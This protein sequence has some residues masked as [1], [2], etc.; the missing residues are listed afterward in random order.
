MATCGRGA[1]HVVC[2]EASTLTEVLIVTPLENNTS[3]LLI[4]ARTHVVY[5]CSLV[6]VKKE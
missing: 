5:E 1:Q 2:N 3:L 4:P 6:L